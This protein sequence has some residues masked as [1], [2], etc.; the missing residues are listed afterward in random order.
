[1]HCSLNLERL[2]LE[3]S[4][5]HTPKLTVGQ[6]LFQCLLSLVCGV[7]NKRDK[8]PQIFVCIALHPSS[9]FT[10]YTI[11][12]Y[13]DLV[14]ILPFYFSHSIETVFLLTVRYTY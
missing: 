11:G 9:K 4:H 2:A 7:I 13:E 12:V 8:M 14:E 3:P 5:L 1:M 10:T 6:K